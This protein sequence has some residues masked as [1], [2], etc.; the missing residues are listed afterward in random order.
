MNDRLVYLMRGLPSCGKSYTARKV[1]GD[2]GVVLE[3]D[4][5]FYSQVGDDPDRYDFSKDLLPAARRWNFERFC[6][7]VVSS[8]SPIV[9]DRGN[10]RNPETREYAQFAVDHDYDIELKEPKSDWWREIRGL[11]KRKR[12]NRECLHAWADKL[13]E[14]SRDGHRVP[15]STIRAWMDG[16]KWDLTIDEILAYRPRPPTW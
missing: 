2:R 3:T 9:V 5:Y 16:W 12:H 10:G 8:V 13:A 1:A 4:E 6:N 14:I 11:L 15:A 7:A